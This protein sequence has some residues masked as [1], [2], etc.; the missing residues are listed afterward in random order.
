MLAPQ[1]LRVGEGAGMTERETVTPARLR[2]INAAAVLVGDH[3]GH[4]AL[5]PDGAR[6][7]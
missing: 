3:D 2:R 7:V 5:A 1:P 6:C 4:T